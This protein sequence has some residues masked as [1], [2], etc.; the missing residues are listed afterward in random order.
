MSQKR[1]SGFT[2]AEVLIVLTIIGVVAS[3]VI[4]SLMN[5]T[6]NDE[7]VIALKKFY[8]ATNQIL[9]KTAVDECSIGDLKCFSDPD[10]LEQAIA[11]QYKKSKICQTGNENQKCFP[12]FNSKYDG[13]GINVDFNNVSYSSYATRFI[14]ADGMSVRLLIDRAYCAPSGAFYTQDLPMYNQCGT[15]DVDVNGFKGPNRWGRDVFSFTVTS[16]KHP[17]LYSPGLKD[18]GAYWNGTAKWC[19][20]SQTDG[21]YC[22]G[23]IIEEGWQMNY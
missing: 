21:R 4:P 16:N 17:I 14:T 11:S 8:A 15:L 19:Q 5:I 7:Y 6:Q 22:S 1:L 18:G 10:K 3:M 13:S 20:Q 2:L 23:R 12:I 9:A